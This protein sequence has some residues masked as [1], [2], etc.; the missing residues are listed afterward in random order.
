MEAEQVGAALKPFHNANLRHA[1]LK[2]RESLQVIDETTQDTVIKAGF[3]GAA[4]E[5]A[6]SM[7][8][9]FRKFIE[10]HRDEIEA[11]QVLYSRPYR[12]GLRYNQV[13]SLAA[14]IKRPPLGLDPARLWHAYQ[15]VEPEKVR[16]QGGGHLVDVIS[17]VKH[18]IEPDSLLVP[19]GDTVEKRYQEWLAE[20][21]AAG[22]RF[23]PEQ[24]KW[25]DAIRDH[26]AKS[27]TIERDDFGD[28]PFNQL[29]GLARAYDV[30]G[31]ALDDI[32]EDLNLRLA[33]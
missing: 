21:D 20:Q 8:S 10:E 2:A 11:L 32:L 24:R 26:I 3:D 25:L 4:T 12:S 17:L 31:P 27:L 9:S 13:K 28:V 16:G 14:E 15:T 33:A 23:T 22:A 29:G 1:I 5:K 6:R 7:V 30:F 19:F 18:A